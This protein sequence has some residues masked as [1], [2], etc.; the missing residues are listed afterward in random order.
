MPRWKRNGDY[1]SVEDY[2]QKK[3]FVLEDLTK[4]SRVQPE[5]IE[6]LAEAAELIREQGLWGGMPTYIIGDYDVDGITSTAI[7]VRL[8]RFFGA[9]PTPIIPRR[10][11]DG[12]GV[13]G[14]LVKDIRDSLIITVD[15]GISAVEPIAAAKEQGNLVVVLDHHLPSDTLPAADIIVD[16]HIHPER[17][18]F[19]PYCGA[20]LSLK[21]AQ[22]IAKT[23]PKEELEKHGNIMRLFSELLFLSTIGTIADVMPMIGDNRWIIQ[24][25]LRA[26][27]KDVDSPFLTA[28][29]SHVGLPVDEETIKFKIAPLLNAH[30][31]LTD[32][33]GLITLQALISRDYTKKEENLTAMI[34][35]NEERK[36]LVD[37]YMNRFTEH[38]ADMEPMNSSK[39]TLLRYD[40]MPEGIT[41]ILANKMAELLHCPVF[42]FTPSNINKDIL[43]GSGRTYNSIDLSGLVPSVSHI[44][45]G[46]GGHAGAAGISVRASRFHELKTAMEEFMESL[47]VEQCDSAMSYD[48]EIHEKDVP[49]ALKALN[50][51]APYGE[52]VPKPVFMLSDFKC[53]Q[54][55]GNSWYRYM[56][57]GETHLK[58]FGETIDVVAF[59]LAG[60]YGCESC[61]QCVDLIGS[62]GTNHF[63][64]RTYLQFLASDFS[65]HALRKEGIEL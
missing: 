16:P 33:G 29:I 44:I 4:P 2:L 19:V 27:N 60:R 41:G 6:N 53:S 37:D 10:F 7:L 63:N 15:N 8:L 55:Q 62:I 21:V 18:G 56:G 14:K 28:M 17:N 61:P 9:N 25:G 36:R 30:G 59:G 1:I 5:E 23:T 58:L 32:D 46:G 50:K 52:G 54:K 47:E 13:S 22:Y 57:A 3:G 20:G 42:V 26:G 35:A 24:H 12:Y 31:R 49:E 64:G 34:Q 43:K 39:I 11:T 38:M 45:E 48:I 51:Y 65:G 40:D